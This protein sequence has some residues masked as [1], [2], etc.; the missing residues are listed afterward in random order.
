[1]TTLFI[2][3]HKGAQDWAKMQGISAE[4][5]EHFNIEML[6]D[7][8]IT[9]VIGTLPINLAFQVCNRKVSY[10]HLSMTVPAD[11]RGTELSAQDMVDFNCKLEEFVVSKK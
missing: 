9:Q 4:V 10:L 7:N 1:M 2:S 6:D 5:V 8:D 3:R 11:R